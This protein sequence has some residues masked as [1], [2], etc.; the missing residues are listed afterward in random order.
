MLKGFWTD[1]LVAVTLVFLIPTGTQCRAE[2]DILSI[3]LPDWRTDSEYVTQCSFRKLRNAVCNWTT[4]Q[5]TSNATTWDRIESEALNQGEACLEFWYLARPDTF[6]VGALLKSSIGLVEIWTSPGPPQDS[7]RQVLVPLS[8]IEPETKVVLEAVRTVF[9]E[10]RMTF[11]NIGIR[12]GS[13][14]T[15]TTKKPQ[16]TPPFSTIPSQT[17]DPSSCPINCDFEKNLCTWQQLIQDTFD[18]TRYSGATPSVGSGPD[19]DHTTGA[20]FYLYIE[21]DHVTRG[22][23]ARLLSTECHHSGPVCLRFWYHMYGSATAMALNIYLL[24]GNK[25]TKI[26]SIKNNHGQEWHLAKVD[27]N[28]SRPFQIIVEGIRGSNALSDVAIDDISIDFSSCSSILEHRTKPP[29]IAEVAPSNPVCSLNCSFDRNICSWKQMITDAFDWTWQSGSTPTLMTGPSFDHTGEGHYLY[30]EANTASHGDTARLISSE[31]STIGPHCLQFWY[32]MYGSADTM[33]LHLYLVQDKKANVIWWKRNDQGNMWQLAQVDVTVTTAFQVIIE[34]RRGSNKESD[35][36][37][38]DITFYHGQCSELSGAMTTRLPKPDGNI[39]ASPN[40]TLPLTAVTELPAVNV[41]DQFPVTAW[42]P[43]T[44]ITVPPV[45]EATTNLIMNDNVTGASH[46]KPPHSVCQ[47]NCDFEKDLCHW[48]QMLTDVFD[49]TRNRGSTPS[50]RTGPSSDH[51]TEDGHYLYIEANRASFGDTARL[52]SSECPASGPQ[53]LQ[54]W[55]HMYGSAHTMGLHVYL[56]QHKKASAIWWKSNDQGNMWHLAEVDLVVNG[57]FQIIFEGRRGANEE[58]DVAIDDVMLYQAQCSELSSVGTAQTPDP[59]GNT[60]HYPSFTSQVTAVT[61]LPSV[62]V[63]DQFPATISSTVANATVRPVTE[64]T[65]NPNSNVTADTQNRPAHSVCQINCDFEKDLC[66]WNQLLVD[67]F[68]WTRLS[69]STQ[70]FGTG[71]SSD[72]TTGHGHYLYIEANSASHG[73][74]ARLI[75]SKCSTSGPQCLQFWYHMY[76]SADTMG[77]HV[78]LLQDKKAD[79]ISWTRNNHGNMWHLAQID[80]TTNGSFQILF[81]ARRGSN[82]QSDV[83]IDDISLSSGRCSDLTK[84]TSPVPMTTDSVTTESFK[85]PINT[86][87]S[88]TQTTRLATS[89]PMHPSASTESQTSDTAHPLSTPAHTPQATNSWTPNATSATNNSDTTAFNGM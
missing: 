40:V 56:L 8:I 78:Y 10:K 71:P 55:Y 30:I 68:D 74:T 79:V 81:E 11:N 54:F 25:A 7:W 1:L 52:I 59:E 60:T 77:L 21:G 61:E 67:V 33:G 22:D 47:F 85:P 50:F 34:G 12:R 69:G 16:A 88:E 4:T 43:V 89:K 27:V 20:G 53:C 9:P 15:Q 36:A 44:N 63:T 72:H 80:F 24:Q 28:V 3:T 41:T 73:D 26:W 57:S 6:K 35:V 66:H 18:W 45:P 70:T 17:A 37:I 42:P 13:C 14:E 29:L 83:A 31:C 46:N 49:W 87:G 58:S 2:N 23:P 32:H 51:T 38:D 62:N 82:D 65:T 39:T 84:P 75:S 76:G 86:T 5:H 48:N 64:A 19:N